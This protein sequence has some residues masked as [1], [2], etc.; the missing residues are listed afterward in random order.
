M[1]KNKEA[2]GS[3]PGTVYWMDVSQRFS[4]W[5]TRTP[6]GTQSVRRGTYSYQNKP[7]KR[8]TK[9]VLGVREEVNFDLGVRKEGSF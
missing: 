8:E 3:N 2:V 1:A 9:G 5:G 6:G 4:T 7:N